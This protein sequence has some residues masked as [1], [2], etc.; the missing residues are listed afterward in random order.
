MQ[1]IKEG[2][3]VRLDG[4][5]V[6]VDGEIVGVGIAQD[7]ESVA[8][9]ME[10]ARLGLAEQFESFA[11][12]TVDF[13]QRER[14]LLF[15][16]EGLPELGHDLAR[17]PVLVVVR[18]YNFRRDLATL[19]PYIR[20][21]RPVL[22][23]VDGGAD[24]LIDYSKEDLKAR[25]KDLTD[26]NGADV[27]YDPVGGAF[28]EGGG[29][30]PLYDGTALANKGVVVVTMNYRLGPYGFFVHPALTAESPRGQATRFVSPR[31]DSRTAPPVATSQSWRTGWGQWRSTSRCWA[32]RNRT[33]PTATAWP[34]STRPRSMTSTKA[35]TAPQA[36]RR[37]APTHRRSSRK[38]GVPTDARIRNTSARPKADRT[39]TR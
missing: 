38:I 23:G 30:V 29:S 21:V 4:D 36:R 1:K 20:D 37:A 28:T 7:E 24:A 27:I 18:G 5:R 11:R 32:S 17:R 13:I 12:N 34:H 14:D 8:R 10:E 3:P 39:I 19:K 22:I 15:S 2:Q 35:A 33:P 6:L 9:A 16:G 31:G 25:V 26:G